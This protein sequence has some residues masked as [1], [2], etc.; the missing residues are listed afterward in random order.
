MLIIDRHSDEPLYM[1][2]YHQLREK[3][4]SGELCEGS[5]LPPIRTLA[6]TLLVA[7]KYG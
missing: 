5:I 3:I 1:Q 4:I 2:I 6:S 7:K